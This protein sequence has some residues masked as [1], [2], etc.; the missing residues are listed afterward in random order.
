[1]KDKIRDIFMV[2]GLTCMVVISGFIIGF[3]LSLLTR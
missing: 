2:I 1:M 3:L